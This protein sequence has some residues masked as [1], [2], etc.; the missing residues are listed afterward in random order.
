MQVLPGQRRKKSCAS[1]GVSFRPTHFTVCQYRL[2]RN[3]LLTISDRMRP[4]VSLGWRSQRMLTIFK[5][6]LDHGKTKKAVCDAPRPS[7]ADLVC[8]VPCGAGTAQ[9]MCEDVPADLCG[10]SSVLPR[11][12]A[13]PSQRTCSCSGLP[14]GLRRAAPVIHS[15]R[16]KHENITACRCLKARW[17]ESARTGAPCRDTQR[18]WL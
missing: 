3:L 15:V 16:P 8:S 18:S 2:P 13:V 6:V 17:E 9:S 4:R 10:R 5:E 12:S 1:G 11:R 7:C 14:P